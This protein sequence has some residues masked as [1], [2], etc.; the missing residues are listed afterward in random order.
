M[1]DSELSSMASRLKEIMDTDESIYNPG[2]NINDLASI[3]GLKEKQVS[4][5]INDYWHLNF[6]A[7]LNTY[8]CREACRRL[9]DPEFANLTIEAVA[10]SLGFRNR[11]H[12]A[13]IF[14]EATGL[15]PS[16][17]RRAVH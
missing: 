17:Y 13:K 3:S 9:S 15:T 2:F 5:T 7:W 16:E 1:D 11:S 6:N 10:E 14:R 8:R 4:Q 12:F